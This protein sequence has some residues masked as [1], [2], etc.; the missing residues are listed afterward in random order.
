MIH[1]VLKNGLKGIRFLACLLS[2]LL[3][4][5]VFSE[6][7]TPAGVR[8]TQPRNGF[9]INRYNFDTYLI[10][11]AADPGKAVAIFANGI[12]METAPTDTLGRFSVQIDFSIYIE[13][14]VSFL[15][16]Q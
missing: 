16:F 3:F 12:L 1:L 8:I 10:R 9:Y 11:G 4:M 7:S 15:T 2:L 14:P 13:R 5:P 6:G